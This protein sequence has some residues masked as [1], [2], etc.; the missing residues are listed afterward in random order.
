[1]ETTGSKQHPRMRELSLVVSPALRARSG[2]RAAAA[3]GPRSISSSCAR[4]RRAGG[5]GAPRACQRAVKSRA[6]QFA[7][8]GCI[9]PRRRA[10][11]RDP[12]RVRLLRGA[13]AGS[14]I[15]QQL[16]SSVSLNVDVPAR[17]D[18]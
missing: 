15:N 2:A 10:R 17:N 18:T 9:Y 1:M 7:N 12:G 14:A 8:F 6:L 5:R 3:E 11:R 4:A 16:R 13:A